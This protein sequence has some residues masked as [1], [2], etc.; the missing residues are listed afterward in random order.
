MLA[1]E[2][3][4]AII[5]S[6]GQGVRMDGKDKGLVNYQDSPMIKQ[7][8]KCI[9]PQVKNIVISCNRNFEVYGA[10]GF[11]L[12]SDRRTTN[13]L[14]CFEGPLAGIQAGLNKIQ[15]KAA[16]IVPCDSP[17][18]P[19][20]LVKR[21]RLKLNESKSSAATPFDGKRVQPLFSL[22]TTAAQKP[23]DDYLNSGQRK[24]DVFFLQLKTEIVDF[25]DSTAHFLNLNTFS[26][27]H[28]P[29]I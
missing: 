9:A 29:A 1:T 3:I 28:K 20:D 10:Y 26:S 2:D 19:Q 13:T 18:I 17:N 24:V 11:P 14:P 4:T 23:L 12:A 22:I 21:L 5:L 7:V 6:G 16:I 8:I 25:S 15:T 27:L